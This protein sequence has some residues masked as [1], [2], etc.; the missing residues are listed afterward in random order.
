MILQF[1]LA[2]VN[3]FYHTYMKLY[4]N[5]LYMIIPTYFKAHR[6]IL[7]TLRKSPVRRFIF[8]IT[9]SRFFL[10]LKHSSIKIPKYLYLDTHSIIS[11]SLLTWYCKALK[12]WTYFFLPINMHLLCLTFNF[13][14]LSFSHLL[15]KSIAP[16]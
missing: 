9:T 16:G 5:N 4:N 15:S 1:F 13:N 11:S 6:K 7:L 14:L 2:F 10:N 12:I 3:H 8:Y